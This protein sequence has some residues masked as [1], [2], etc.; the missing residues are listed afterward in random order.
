MKELIEP[1][2]VSQVSQ[3]ILGHCTKIV[4][5]GQAHENHG[6][7]KVTLYQ[8]VYRDCHNPLYLPPLHFESNKGVQ[9][10]LT[11]Q[12]MGFLRDQGGTVTTLQPVF[13]T[14]RHSARAHRALADSDKQH[15]LKIHRNCRQ[16]APH[17]DLHHQ[18]QRMNELVNLLPAKS[19]RPPDFASLPL[20]TPKTEKLILLSPA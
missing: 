10:A 6:G 16:P 4:E 20:N 3:A 17:K 14:I 8:E 2:P 11:S 1:S 18:R 9:Q 15:G 12:D 5:D 13:L 7:L 19:T